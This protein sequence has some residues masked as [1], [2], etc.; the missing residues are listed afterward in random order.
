MTQWTDHYNPPQPRATAVSVVRH[1]FGEEGAFFKSHPP[2]HRQ[3]PSRHIP[4]PVLGCASG[5]D[6]AKR[7]GL[8]VK[9][10]LEAW[11]APVFD[12]MTA[13]KPSLA[14]STRAAAASKPKRGSG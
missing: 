1:A 8:L 9:A 4:Q 6:E 13:L 14:Q 2:M 3:L 5:I 7:K 12:L 11:P 10:R